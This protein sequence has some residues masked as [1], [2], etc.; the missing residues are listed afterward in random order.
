MDVFLL[1]ICTCLS[2]FII[3]R[4]LF[5]FMN[6]RYQKTFQSKH[7]YYLLLKLRT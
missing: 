4:I 5:Q 2:C 1:A 3:A 7:I 6:D